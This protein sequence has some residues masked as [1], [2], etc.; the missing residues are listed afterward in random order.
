M[1][2]REIFFTRGIG[3]HSEKLVSFELAL[4]KA[5]IAPY[6]LV[7]VSSILPPNCKI[8]DRKHGLAKLSPGEIIFVV[9]ADNSSCEPNRLVSAS[10]GVA[11]PAE[12]STY[13]YL[14]EEHCFGMDRKCAG[15]HVEELATSM[16]ASKLGI[17]HPE[18]VE[19]NERKKAYM[20]SEKIF[21]TM[22]FTQTVVV[23]K[24]NK[25]ATAVSAAVFVP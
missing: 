3:I 16:L 5:G 11:V 13:G 6:N 24:G 20:V 25:W 10:I 17:A 8:I 19:W 9:L 4:R 2:P 1:V 14:A 21:K 22:H 18:N 23:P 12:G 7:R 15:E